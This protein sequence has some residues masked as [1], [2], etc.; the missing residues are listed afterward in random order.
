MFC[1]LGGRQNDVSQIA[2]WSCVEAWTVN[3]F[4]GDYFFYTVRTQTTLGFPS[5]KP[6]KVLSA[7]ICT[8]TYVYTYKY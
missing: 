1:L 8:C 6:V 2:L 4:A 7:P 3:L 5:C